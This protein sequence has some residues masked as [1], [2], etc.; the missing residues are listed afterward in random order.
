MYENKAFDNFVIRS[1]CTYRS[2]P[3]HSHGDNPQLSNGG[4]TDFTTPLPFQTTWWYFCR[5]F[6]LLCNACFQRKICS[7][8]LAFSFCPTSRCKDKGDLLHC[9]SPSLFVF[10]EQHCVPFYGLL[11]LLELHANVALVVDAFFITDSVL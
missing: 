1:T 4:R 3:G 10:S 8:C 11:D 5:L 2:K 9:K 7:R 6:Q